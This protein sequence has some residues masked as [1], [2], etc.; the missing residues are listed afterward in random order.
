MCKKRNTVTAVIS[1]KGTGA[2]KIRCD[3]CIRKFLQ[4]LNLHG[5]ETVGSC[6]GHRRYPLTII[7]K[8]IDGRY[9]ELISGT[10]IPRTRN[11]YKMDAKGFYYIP[12]TIGGKHG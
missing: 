10:D 6:C 1:A 5:I 3:E 7:C 4:V 8:R 9:F 11:F 12:E 2:K